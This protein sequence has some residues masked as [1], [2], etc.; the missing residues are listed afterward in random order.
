MHEDWDLEKEWS[1]GDIE[2]SKTNRLTGCD[3]QHGKEISATDVSDFHGSPVEAKGHNLKHTQASPTSR[4]YGG[5]GAPLR[6]LQDIN[7]R[8]RMCW[9]CVMRP[10]V[11]G[12]Y[13]DGLC[14]RGAPCV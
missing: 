12:N 2:N 8:P 9:A 11:A 13:G 7:D 4:R 5:N 1:E 10:S 6:H 14:F 3:R